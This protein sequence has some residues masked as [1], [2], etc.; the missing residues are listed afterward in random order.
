MS[1]QSDEP[2]PY[3]GAQHATEPIAVSF[4]VEELDDE[5]CWRLIA[6]GSLG[7]LAVVAGDGMPD[8]FP[9]NFLVRDRHIFLRT[10]P[11]GKLQ[12]V[13][14]RPAVAFEVDGATT[15]HFWSVVVHGLAQRLDADDAIEMSG[16]LDL[17]SLN[18]IPK[19]DF[20]ELRPTTITGRRFPRGVRA[21]SETG[22]PCSER[23]L[24]QSWTCTTGLGT[25]RTGFRTC[26]PARRRDND[27]PPREGG[28]CA[29][30]TGSP[31]MRGVGVSRG[32]GAPLK[33]GTDTSPAPATPISG[34]RM[35]RR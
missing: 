22:S 6:R 7:R 15:T 5:E 4:G 14:A 27:N 31:S 13:A 2:N 35:P 23:A 19:N 11:G 18:P 8:V 33:R 32:G 21:S 30:N 34:S 26:R 28:L 25:S 1:T 3:A 20:V 24:R 10:A 12:S 29:T 9:M 16:V 17:Q